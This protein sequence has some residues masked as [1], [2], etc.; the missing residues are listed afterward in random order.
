RYGRPAKHLVEANRLRPDLTDVRRMM[1]EAKNPPPRSFPWMQF[2]TA[3][4]VVAIA[5]AGVLL[6]MRWRRSRYRIRPSEV[7]RLI[8]ASPEAPPIILHVRDGASS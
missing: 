6:A 5:V 3:V 4:V 1:A 2:A 8:E 7:M